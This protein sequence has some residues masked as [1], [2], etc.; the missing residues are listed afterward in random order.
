MNPAV[1]VIDMQ[2]KYLRFVSE[3]K[4]K[5]IVK[6][7]IDLLNECVIQDIPAVLVEYENNG[8]TINGIFGAWSKVPVKNLII[9]PTEN[10]FCKTR[11]ERILDDWN[12]EEVI[13]A[14]VETS[15]CVYRTA[16]GA[17]A[18]RYKIATSK[19]LISDPEGT[20]SIQ[21]QVFDY[22][23]IKGKMFDTNQ[24]LMNYLKQ[25]ILI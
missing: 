5:T 18:G 13:I 8:E 1:L 7:Q 25:A 14:G 15:V 6:S 20:H 23:K 22:F 11:L 10:A 17:I 21:E 4:R 2:E 9:K 24:E 12:T 3:Q 19:D 16:I